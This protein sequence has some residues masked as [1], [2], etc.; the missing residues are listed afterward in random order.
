MKKSRKKLALH[1]QTIGNL[2]N[3]RLSEAAGGGKFPS[4]AYTYCA[5]CN[6]CNCPSQVDTE[7]CQNTN[8]GCVESYRA[9]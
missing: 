8:L 2:T 7:C 4:G 5:T 6:S 1:R 3:D 9:C